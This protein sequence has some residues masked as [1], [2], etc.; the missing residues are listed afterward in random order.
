M[1]SRIFNKVWGQNKDIFKSARTLSLASCGSFFRKQ[2]EYFSKMRKRKRKRT[3]TQ[4]AGNR[5]RKTIQGGSNI[6]EIGPATLKFTDC[7]MDLTVW[8]MI[9]VYIL[10]VQLECLEKPECK[11][12]EN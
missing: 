6:Y 1:L 9:F 2:P 3:R 12:I 11:C 10:I 7:L 8:K 4:K 5:H